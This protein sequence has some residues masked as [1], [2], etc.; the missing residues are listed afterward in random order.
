MFYTFFTPLYS[1]TEEENGKCRLVFSWKI[2]AGDKKIWHLGNIIKEGE[3]EFREREKIEGERERERERGR[4]RETDRQR[5]RERDRQTERERV[6][7]IFSF[8]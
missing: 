8:L 5:E 6:H 3:R 2:S 4:E 7:F 1:N